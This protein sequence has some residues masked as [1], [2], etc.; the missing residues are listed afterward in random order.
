MDEITI[1][2]IQR[3]IGYEFSNKVLLEQAFVRKS[4][5]Q[6]HP[7][8]LSNEVLEFYGDRALDFYITIAM[9]KKFSVI[10]LERQFFS[11][12]NE[13]E[14]TKIKASNVDTNSLSHCIDL[15]D[16]Q[17]YLMMNESD[18]K[19]EAYNSSH[20]KE[21]LFEAI[22]G[23]VAIDSHWNLEK[24]KNACRTMLKMMN[25]E[26]NYIKLVDEWS[27]SKGYGLAHYSPKEH[28]FPINN[29]KKLYSIDNFERKDQLATHYGCVLWF[30][31]CDLKFESEIESSYAAQM[32]CA[33]QCYEYIQGLKMKE[34]IGELNPTDSVN[35]LNVLFQK[36]Y[37]KEPQYLF[38]ET[39]DENGNP[40]WNC[41]GKISEQ[42]T[43]FTAESAVKKD[44][45][46]EVAFKILS[47]LFTDKR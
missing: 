31:K 26:I 40:I 25:F 5:S 14:L 2:H 20:V 12:K 30:L 1:K 15:L 42:E 39:H 9:E 38:T 45:K 47:A 23:A 6:E 32:D 33:K 44:A 21:D 22:I 29:N 8:K 13:D 46:K 27:Q 18:I 4:Y 10:T 36:G 41:K 35:Q 19:N 11:E 3:V 17:K 16:L 28:S 24:I 43:A 37:I 7:E 34:A